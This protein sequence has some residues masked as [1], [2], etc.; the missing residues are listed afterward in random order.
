MKDPKN[1]LREYLNKLI[2]RLLFIKG[3]N[4]QL[5][6]LKEWETPRRV[7]ALET[8]SYFFKLVE[9][10]F[11]RTILIELCMFFNEREDKGLIDWLN[12]AKEHAKILRPSIYN[13]ETE[14]R[15]I[16]KPET[17]QKIISGQQELINSKKEIISNIK[18][19]RD[20]SLTHSDAKYFNTPE[21]TYVT[22]P[23]TNNDI[24][25]IIEIATQILRMQ[26]IYL[27]KSDLDI[28]VH[29][30]S[31]VDTIL[32]HTRAFKRVWN[33]KR[34]KPLYPYLYKLDDYEE[35]LKEHLDKKSVN[36]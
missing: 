12:K 19:R 33:D 8:G 26:H 2:R 20:T 16:L 28:Q 9:F 32:R 3:L 6:L 30:T 15:E 21:D 36:A 34:A 27:F 29:A 18:G 22:F 31:N 25:S 17:Y 10:S 7:I 14:K 11:Y 13:D 24:D 35:K 5:N 23:L 4:K 1:E